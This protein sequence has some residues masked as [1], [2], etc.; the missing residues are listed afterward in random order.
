[1]MEHP[2][3]NIFY[4]HLPRSGS[5]ELKVNQFRRRSTTNGGF[6]VEIELQDQTYNFV[7]PEQLKS[8]QTV[9]VA[10][11]TAG[12]EGFKLATELKADGATKVVWGVNTNVFTKVNALMMSPN[13]WDGEQTG[14]KHYFFMLDGCANEGQARGFFNEF[15]REDLTQHRKTLEM[16]GSKLQTAPATQQLSGLGFSSTQ[17]NSVLAKVTGAFTR[18]VKIVF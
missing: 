17:R 5:F 15:L 7:H 18:V 9:T 14:N 6:E 8:G 16:V 1:M 13:Y 2:V 10:K 12:T 3:E 11:F 4:T